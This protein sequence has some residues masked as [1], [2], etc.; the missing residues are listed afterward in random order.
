MDT[1]NTTESLQEQKPEINPAIP[2]DGDARDKKRR[3]R[4]AHGGGTI[5]ARISPD[6]FRESLSKQ[7]GAIPTWTEEELDRIQVDPLQ[8][9]AECIR[10]EDEHKY[11][12]CWIPKPITEGDRQML[13][14]YHKDF[15]ATGR[16]VYVTRE[17]MGHEIEDDSVFADSGAIERGDLALGVMR[18]DVWNMMRE[19]DRHAGNSQYQRA[20]R[21]Q[22]ARGAIPNVMMDN[23][24]GRYD[25][26][27]PEQFGMELDEDGNWV[28]AL[29]A[30]HSDS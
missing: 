28:E 8:F 17:N 11:K 22:D 20:R 19:R 26:T 30:F 10:L 27:V 3:H 18:W 14:L 9:P 15:G 1:E 23:G 6:P 12:F 24:E 13:G 4:P 16:Y 21:G 2:G 7:I 29:P 25:H 5:A